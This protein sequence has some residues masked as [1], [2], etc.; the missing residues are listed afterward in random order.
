MFQRVDSGGPGDFLE[1]SLL[2]RQHYNET[3]NGN[4]HALNH[5]NF[6]D[7]YNHDHNGLSIA[8][9]SLETEDEPDEAVSMAKDE[10]EAGQVKYV[11]DDDESSSVLKHSQNLSLSEQIQYPPAPL[12]ESFDNQNHDKSFDDNNNTTG[13]DIVLQGLSDLLQSP[14]RP[15]EP[16]WSH[17][18]A[19]ES[20]LPAGESEDLSSSEPIP[21]QSPTKM[22]A[23]LNRLGKL[24]KKVTKKLKKPET[25][26]S[27]HAGD[28]QVEEVAEGSTTPTASSS[29]DKAVKSSNWA[30]KISKIATNSAKSVANS[31]Q[32]LSPLK[33]L[34]G[35]KL[36]RLDSME[37]FE[38][39]EDFGNSSMPC[40][41]LQE[42]EHGSATLPSVLKAPSTELFSNGNDI[43]TEQVVTANTILLSS[44]SSELPAVTDH[45]DCDKKED[46]NDTDYYDS[47]SSDCSGVDFESAAPAGTV[48]VRSTSGCIQH[49]EITFEVDA[50]PQATRVIPACATED[51]T[52][53][54]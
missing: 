16:L 33:V 54:L 18:Y 50:S 2:L 44:V 51:P 30:E 5:S 26:A 32:P 48:W 53:F 15:R 11:D 10:K 35:R 19:T 49:L 46:G 28:E 34:K 31:V 17:D 13:L 38:S 7:G 52:R 14:T 45:D 24:K 39:S 3:K 41:N 36:E 43:W 4:S 27:D 40:I 47:G 20:P 29:K 12:Q 23:A 21:P 37:D 42:M 22:R 8:F 1:P 9:P 25:M 6:D